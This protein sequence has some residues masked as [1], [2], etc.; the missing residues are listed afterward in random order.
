MVYSKVFDTYEAFANS[1]RKGAETH[2]KTLPF[3]DFG[4]AVFG[5]YVFP[6]ESGICLLDP[7][8]DEYPAA[9]EAAMSSASLVVWMKFGKELN[10]SATVFET[11]AELDAVAQAEPPPITYRL[12]NIPSAVDYSDAPSG[13]SRTYTVS[14]DGYRRA[15][16]KLTSAALARYR[17]LDWR[18]LV[19]VMDMS[20]VPVSLIPE[21]SVA[22]PN[23]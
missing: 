21:I 1:L 3:A 14:L 20:L 16:R 12:G 2:A 5:C 7:S 17:G 19:G 11:L 15:N 13:R 8:S 23:L 22:R 10:E 4:K 9:L 6:P 18:F